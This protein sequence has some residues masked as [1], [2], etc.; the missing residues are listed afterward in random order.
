VLLLEITAQF[1][2]IVWQFEGL[3][4]FSYEANYCGS[5]GLHSLILYNGVSSV[6]ACLTFALTENEKNQTHV[7]FRMQDVTED[8]T[9]TSE[10]D[11]GQH[12]STIA[13]LQQVRLGLKWWFFP[14][15]VGSY[16]MNDMN[17]SHNLIVAWVVQ[18]AC[19]EW[20]SELLVIHISSW[21]V[22]VHT[23]YHWR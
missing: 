13:S 5:V 3:F 22:Q 1:F 15:F 14:S 7:A 9:V 20:S 21:L 4:L 12:W 19:W 2:V 8:V 18:V 10:T 23:A 11:G 17:I 16:D 6:V